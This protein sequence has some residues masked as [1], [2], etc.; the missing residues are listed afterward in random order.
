MTLSSSIK[1]LA[2]RG[3]AIT[4]ISA[5]RYVLHVEG[6]RSSSLEQGPNGFLFSCWDCA[7]GPGPDDFR[8]AFGVLDDAL[9]AAWYFYFGQA[10]GVDG[11][12]I[13]MHQHPYWSLNRLAYRIANAIHLTSDQFE[14]MEES[15]QRDRMSR[16]TAGLPPSDGRYAAALR[17]QFV[18][19]PSATS[20]D[21]LMLRRDLEE[22]YVVESR[23]QAA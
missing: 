12:C 16:A 17:S 23:G 11:W 13:P 7:P 10:V 22:A 14:V 8:T 19:C 20:S 5:N 21:T 15:R 3:I 4:E 18:A 6:K 1:Y 9:L 2:E